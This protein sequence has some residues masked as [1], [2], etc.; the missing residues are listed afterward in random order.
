MFFIRNIFI[1]NLNVEYLK[2]QETLTTTFLLL[3][4]KM[5]NLFLH[6][7]IILKRFMQESSFQEI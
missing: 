1:R 7:Y 3:I 4:L 2:N 6:E 5:K